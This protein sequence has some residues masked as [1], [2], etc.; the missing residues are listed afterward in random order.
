MREVGHLRARSKT[1]GSVARVRNALIK[2]SHDFYQGKGFLYL[3]SPLLSTSECE[4]AGEMFQVTTLISSSEDDPTK[5]PTIP[6]T[7]KLDY[8]D[9]LLM[10]IL[11]LIII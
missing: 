6:E 8:K 2:A 5:L 4:G 7:N 3:H 10:F 9:V 11:E 1:I